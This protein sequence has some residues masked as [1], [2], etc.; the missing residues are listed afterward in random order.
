VNEVQTVANAAGATASQTEINRQGAR[1]LRAYHAACVAAA[2][3]SSSFSSSS[4]GGGGS[5]S[6]GDDKADKANK[7][8]KADGAEGGEA[9][10]EVDEVGV[11]D[12]GSG[13]LV[14]AET[15]LDALDVLVEAEARKGEKH[16]DLLLVSCYAARLLH[17]A[18][19]TSCKSAKDRSSAFQTLE[20]A[21]LLERWG[22]LDR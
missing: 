10:D 15:L 19:T 2:D 3:G 21:R 22:W 18:R 1:S 16:V 8:N 7:A 6:S 20:V 17:G 11:G 13:R 9:E 5:H 4:G 12:G 14:E